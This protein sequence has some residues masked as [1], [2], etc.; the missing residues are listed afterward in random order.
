MTPELLVELNK[1][2]W[3]RA[4]AHPFR[5]MKFE[6][7]LR[8]DAGMVAPS[9]QNAKAA[10]ARHLALCKELLEVVERLR[11]LSEDAATTINLGSTPVDDRNGGWPDHIAMAVT[12]LERLVPG[13]NSWAEFLEH[14][15]GKSRRGGRKNEPAYLIAETLAEIYVIGLRKKPTIGKLVDG[16]GPSG[17]FGKV[18]AAVFAILKVE[19]SDVIRPCKAAIEGLSESRMNRLLQDRDVSIFGT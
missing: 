4:S 7:V 8:K 1:I 9:P 2:G 16:T 10:L 15:A 5:K 11:A 13:L 19:K 12:T 17:S 18:T 3:K 6:R 14:E